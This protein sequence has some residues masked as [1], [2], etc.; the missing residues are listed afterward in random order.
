MLCCDAKLCADR[1]DVL[2]KAAAHDANVRSISPNRSF[3]ASKTRGD[4]LLE[5]FHNLSD[6]RARDR[7]HREPSPKRL[8]NADA[9]LHT[10]A[11]DALDHEHLG[12]AVG[13]IDERD[14]RDFIEALRGDDGGVE[15]EDE[16]G[17]GGGSHRTEGTNPKFSREQGMT[18]L[19][20]EGQP[21][22]HEPASAGVG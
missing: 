12:F 13:V 14:P 22:T 9:A 1:N 2:A 6:V 8:I 4:L 17:L 11:R 18:R 7:E 21:A 10:V 19:P 3:A 20:L 5:K 15:V 16:G